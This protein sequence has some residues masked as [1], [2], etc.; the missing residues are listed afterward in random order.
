MTRTLT[1]IAF[2]IFA[3]VHQTYAKAPIK[4]GKIDIEDLKMTVYEPDTSA[5]A[6]VLCKYGY[7]NSNN[8]TFTTTTRVKILKKSGV[9]L[10]EFTFP[11]K[12]DMQIRGKVYNLENGEVVEERLK[13][14]SIFKLKVTEDYYKM[15]VALPNI[16]VGSIYDIETSQ[17]LLPSEFAFQRDIPIKHCELQLDPCTEIE[18][19]KRARGFIMIKNVGSG[20]FALDTVPAFKEEPYIDS[21]ENYISK[22]EFDILNVS[23]PGYYKGFTTS[24]EAVNKRL[25]ANNYFGGALTNGVGALNPI[26]KEIE[27][28]YSDPYDKMVAAYEAI[29]KIKWNDIESLFA[30]NEHLGGVYKDKKGNSADINMMLYQLLNKLDVYALPVVISTRDNGTLHQFYPSLE[31]LNYMLVRVK[32]EDTE[33]L[34]DATEEL[35]PVDMVPLRCLNKSGRLVNNE[36]GKWIDLK[37]DKKDKSSFIFNLKLDENLEAEGTMQCAKCDYS[38]YRFRKNYKGYASEDEFLE[39]METEHPGLRIKDFTLTDVDSI[40]KDVREEYQVKVSNIAQKVGDMIMINPFLFEREEDNP[41]KLEERNYPVDFAYK[42]EKLVLSNLTIPDGYVFETVPKPA[43][44]LLPEK[45]GSVLVSYATMGNRLRV[46]YKFSLN[47]TVFYPKE[48]EYLKQLFALTIEKQAEP[49]IIKKSEDA[50]SL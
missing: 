37:T 42:K 8:Y 25:R 17:L 19:R 3:I 36:S 35:M 6:V 49:V 21:K 41:F 12:E 40:Y 44:I 24:W 15:R 13:N 38:A 45:G 27:G 1:L 5:A 48:Y 14:E 26:K 31:K 34:L 30:S 46:T 10:S 9:S 7:F 4:F 20:R 32:I 16:K 11:G 39:A 33:Y 18:Y 50:A 47:K 23:F 22:F 43:R 2:C 29:K 28:K